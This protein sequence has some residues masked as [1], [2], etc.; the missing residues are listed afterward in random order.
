MTDEFSLPRPSRIYIN[1]IHRIDV[2]GEQV[3]TGGVRRWGPIK[4]LTDHPDEQIN[5]PPACG[6]NGLID[7]WVESKKTCL[8]QLNP[9]SLKSMYIGLKAH[10]TCGVDEINERFNVRS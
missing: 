2:R 6:S 3:W 4:L 8:S 1:S 5:P 9:S 7:W 10:T